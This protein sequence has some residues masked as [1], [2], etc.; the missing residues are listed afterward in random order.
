MHPRRAVFFLSA[1]FVD[2]T[3][4]LLALRHPGFVRQQAFWGPGGVQHVVSKHFFSHTSY[5][6]VKM[7]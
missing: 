5:E 1:S 7:R 2:S 3:D 6:K 4:F